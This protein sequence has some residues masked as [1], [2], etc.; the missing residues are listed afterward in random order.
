V[1]QEV[2][3]EKAIMRAQNREMEEKRNRKKKE[4]LERILTFDWVEDVDPFPSTKNGLIILIKTTSADPMDT[5]TD[6]NT[7]TTPNAVPT[8]QMNHKPCDVSCFCSS[9][10]NPWGSLHHWHCSHYS[11]ATC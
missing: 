7:I 5:S 11:H 6:T 4:T 8:T 1:I 3:A 10:P 9:T 2:K